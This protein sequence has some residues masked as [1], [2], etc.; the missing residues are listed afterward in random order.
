M[1]FCSYLEGLIMI[2]RN[3]FSQRLRDVRKANH[4]TQKE[5]GEKL[6]VIKQTVNGWEKCVSVPSLDTFTELCDFFDVPADYLLGRDTPTPDT[7]QS[8]T[9]EGVS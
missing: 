3:V 4:L 6:N 9:V 8:A 7:S 5:L 1:N 2:D